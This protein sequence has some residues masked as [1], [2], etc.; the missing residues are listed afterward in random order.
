MS[1][2]AGVIPPLPFARLLLM[3]V[4]TDSFRHGLFMC[5]ASIVLAWLASLAS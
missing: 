3:N 5:N 1:C 4:F 2:I